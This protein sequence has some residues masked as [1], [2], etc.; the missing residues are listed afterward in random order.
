MEE[1][2]KSAAISN[3]PEEIAI[4]ADSAKVY[5]K[6]GIKAAVA[7]EIEM[8][9]ELGKRRYQDPAEIGYL[10]ASIGDKEQAFAWL[11]K[12]RAEKSS[13]VEP[14]K[15]VKALDQWHNDPLYIDLLKQLGLP[16]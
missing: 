14:V 10:Y 9:K 2:K 15:I 6:S 16:Q 8:R 4:A 11:D 12:A 1:W 13:G 7:R 3:D 5:A